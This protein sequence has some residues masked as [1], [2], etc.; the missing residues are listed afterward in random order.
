LLLML[1][2]LQSVAYAAYSWEFKS[3]DSIIGD[4]ESFSDPSKYMTTEPHS[5]TVTVRLT[6]LGTYSTEHTVRYSTNGGTSWTYL[7]HVDDWAIVG[8]GN[9]VVGWDFDYEIETVAGTDYIVQVINILTNINEDWLI[10][11]AKD[12]VPNVIVMEE[13]DERGEWPE[14]EVVRAYCPAG[15]Q[16]ISG[17]CKIW[18]GDELELVESYNAG[19]IGSNYY[20]CR[21]PYSIGEDRYTR[22]YAE[23]YQ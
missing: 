12:P 15:S 8:A 23:C 6:A 2:A 4:F 18:D 9:I 21:N 14:T 5:G 1:F 10:I 19:S 13:G 17:Y 16:I 7:N 11:D 22:A 3:V 20:E